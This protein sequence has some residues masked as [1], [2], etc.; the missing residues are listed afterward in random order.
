MAFDANLKKIQFDLMQKGY[1]LGPTKDDGIWGQYTAKA[2]SDALAGT[3]PSA[4][5]KSAT[6]TAPAASGTASKSAG[7]KGWEDSNDRVFVSY[8]TDP[9]FIPDPDRTE[10][11]NQIRWEGQQKARSGFGVNS[12]YR[13]YDSSMSPQ[14]NAR[15]EYAKKMARQGYNDTEPNGAPDASPDEK[16]QADATAKAFGVQT[17]PNQAELNKQAFNE[18]AELLAM[19]KIA[20]LR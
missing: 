6:T 4:S 10:I 17:N 1:D 11:Q 20:G 3:P 12:T 16:A 15:H 18:S 14:M 2:V 13:N 19:L 9:S 8:K 5:S 7:T